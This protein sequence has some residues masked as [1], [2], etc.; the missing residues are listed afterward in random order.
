M[1]VGVVN[2]GEITSQPG[3]TV[4]ETP[5]S[6]KGTE[7]VASEK[8]TEQAGGEKSTT[9][10]SQAGSQ[11]DRRRGPTKL[12]TIRELR[13]RLREQKSYWEGEVGTLKQRLD[14]IQQTIASR[15]NGTRPRK[16]FWEAPEEVLD[17]RITGHLSEM[18]KRILSTLQQNTQVNQETTEWRQETSEAAKFIQSQRDVTADD[19]EDIAEIVRETPAMQ[20]MRPMDRAKY[21]YYL[22]K[23]ERGIGD[24][25]VAK[26]R[27][28]TVVGQPPASG[29]AKQWTE[30]EIQ[31]EIS[32]FPQ[33][34]KLSPEQVKAFDALEIEI[35][36][37][38]A[39]GRVKK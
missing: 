28:Q 36:K 10:G 25:S 34:G 22:W 9:E 23:Q 21:A 15:S 37:A 5:E 4:T 27:A 24:R 32:K 12:D 3:A 13:S 20:S 30:A 29:G 14:E 33:D 8:E 11:D 16:T 17:E 2:A 18:E 38:Y 26:A 19:E 1:S 7:S 39:E 6:S 35:R 31:T